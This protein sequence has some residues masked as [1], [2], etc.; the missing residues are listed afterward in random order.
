MDKPGPKNYTTE[1]LN[2]YWSEMGY[3]IVLERHPEKYIYQY[4][5]P[6]ISTS[7]SEECSSTLSSSHLWKDGASTRTQGAANIET[8]A[9]LVLLAKGLDGNKA[10][11][12]IF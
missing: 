9:F 11:P 5:I 10:E 3:D 4:Y 1:N 2:M 8:A 7:L 6:C 12:S